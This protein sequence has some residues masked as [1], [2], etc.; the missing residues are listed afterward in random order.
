[1]LSSV[2]SFAGGLTAGRNTTCLGKDLDPRATE[3]I[4]CIVLIF[5]D[6]SILV[7]A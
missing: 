6:Q 5:L 3:K 4:T 2:Q 7:S 1:M